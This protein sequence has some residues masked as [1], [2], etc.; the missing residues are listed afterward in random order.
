MEKKKILYIV[1]TLKKGGPVNIIKNIIR[2]LDR[3]F[4][5]VI[6]LTLSKEPKNSDKDFFENNLKVKVYSLNTSRVKGIFCLKKMINDFIKKNNIDLVHSHG[7]RPDI[8]SSFSP[9]S[10]IT[11]L[12][13]NP[14]LDYAY[15]FG[16]IKGYLIAKIHLHFIKKF[17]YKISCSKYTSEI[18]RKKTDIDFKFIQ[19]GINLEDYDYSS[20]DRLKKELNLSNDDIVFISVGVLNNR[21]DPLTIINAF[22]MIKNERFKLLILGDGKLFENCKKRAINKNI[23]F[24][25]MVNNVFE[26]LKISNYFISASLAEGLPNSV[27]EA[28][29]VGL[30]CLLSNIP[31]H[32]EVLDSDKLTKYIFKIKDSGDL[33]NKI[34][35]ITLDDY[36]EL[37][38]IS[39]SIVKSNFTVK[40]MSQKYQALYKKSAWNLS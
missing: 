28:M 22:N 36:K 16:K 13:N 4:F 15:S 29:G 12:H 33:L 30:P 1:S 7:L 3:D 37:S 21:K 10:K 5:D 32:C 14:F 26:Y 35:Q 19:N 2:Y 24:S 20:K 38:Q 31:S 8:F 34:N 27:L 18:L 17:D 25:G 9:V 39:K 23:L 11:T 6:I 40:I